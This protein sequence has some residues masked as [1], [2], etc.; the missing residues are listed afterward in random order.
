VIYLYSNWW[1]PLVKKKSFRILKIEKGRVRNM[2]LPFV[3]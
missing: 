1:G 2:A 3:F